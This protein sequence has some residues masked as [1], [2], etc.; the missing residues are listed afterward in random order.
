MRTSSIRPLKHSLRDAVAADA[1]LAR[2]SRSARP[3]AGWLRDL[4]AVDVEPQRRR[5]PRSWRDGVQV[6]EPEPAPGRSASTLGAGEHVRRRARRRRCWRTARTASAPVLSFT[7]T[8]RQLPSAVGLAPTPRASCRSSRSSAARSAT[9]TQSLMP[10]ND[11]ALPKRPSGDARRA[12]DRAVVAVRRCPSPWCPRP[13]RSRRRRR[14]P[15]LWTLDGA[16]GRGASRC[17]VASRATAVSVCRPSAVVVVSQ[18]TEY[19]AR[20][21][22]GCRGPG[23]R[24]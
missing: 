22:G 7:I 18:L 10:S 24:A 16:R 15:V 13:R 6:A 9:V 19:G 5:R 11:S 3:V 20:G 23:R 4:G 2:C 1:Q 17:R 12:G 21:V 8:E 14:A